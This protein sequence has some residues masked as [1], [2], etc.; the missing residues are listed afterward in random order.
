MKNSIPYYISKLIYLH[1]CVII[2]GFGGFVGSQISSKINKLTGEITPPSKQILFNKNLNTNDGLL[3]SYVAEEEGITNKEAD[4]IVRNY[5]LELKD[6][7]QKSKILRIKEIG[8]FVIGKEKN[9]IFTQDTSVNYSLDS[10]GMTHIYSKKVVHNKI[11]PTKEIQ[12]NIQSIRRD[13][14]FINKMM[15][16]A[17]IILPLIVLSYLSVSQQNKINTIYMQMANLNPFYKATEETIISNNLE[18]STKVK[19]TEE[20]DV[21]IEIPVIQKEK[22]YIIGGAFSKRENA[23]KLALKLKQWHYNTEILEN[24]SL[25]RVSYNSF[26]NKEKALSV[27]SNIRKENKS[28]WI[29]TN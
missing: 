18:V 21:P 9:I 27:L 15:K 20:V 16:V 6:K 10:F 13:P 12:K 22:F 8:L 25:F 1:D 4:E 26:S 29:L 24:G 28:A 19:S 14:L 5:V 23:E 2:P 3:I 17:A 7:L 11:L